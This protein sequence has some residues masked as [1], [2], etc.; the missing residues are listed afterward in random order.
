MNAA[1]PFPFHAADA[2]EG[3]A[4]AF[5]LSEG[6]SSRSASRWSWSSWRSS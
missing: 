3:Y 4:I 2:D 1:V 6:S 5:V